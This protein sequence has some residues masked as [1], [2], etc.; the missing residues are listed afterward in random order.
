[1]ADRQRRLPHGQLRVGATELIRPSLQD[2]PEGLVEVGFGALHWAR[3]G[4]PVA[5]EGAHS[6]R[7]V[8][9]QASG[10]FG[11]CDDFL[12]VAQIFSFFWRRGV[13]KCI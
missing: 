1:V 6:G 13:V 3:T 10:D 4:L 7:G 2:W 9:L 5:G 8:P 12:Y 11:C